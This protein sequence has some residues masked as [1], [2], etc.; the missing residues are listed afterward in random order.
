MLYYMYPL[1]EI[2]IG[3]LMLAVILLQVF[4]LSWGCSAFY[5]LVTGKDNW[6]IRLLR[7]I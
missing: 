7:K 1:F 4:I 5:A 2:I 3:L 6:A